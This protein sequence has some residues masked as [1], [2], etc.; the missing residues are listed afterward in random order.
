MGEVMIYNGKYTID[1]LRKM[2][3]DAMSSRQEGTN[4]DFKAKWDGCEDKD[5]LSMLNVLYQFSF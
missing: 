1:Q 5:Y 4:Y 3:L 2:V